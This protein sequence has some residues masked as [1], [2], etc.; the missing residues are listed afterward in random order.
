[1]AEY[2]IA[3]PVLSYPEELAHAIGVLN[4]HLYT[5]MMIRPRDEPP[6]FRCYA[7]AFISAE[8]LRSAGFDTQVVPTSVIVDAF[9]KDKTHIDGLELDA[10]QAWLPGKIAGHAIV[11]IHAGS[12]DKDKKTYLQG[13]KFGYTDLMVDGV[14]VP[15]QPFNPL[16]LKD[17]PSYKRGSDSE[18]E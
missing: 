12:N 6:W 8:F 15:H 4:K 9:D 1:M 14:K 13:N 11:E 17:I 18:L 16:T 10:S 5:V 3:D 7:C 2:A